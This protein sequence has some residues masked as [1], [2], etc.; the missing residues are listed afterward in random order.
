MIYVYPVIKNFQKG[1]S[2]EEFHFPTF[3]PLSP[4]PLAV[5]IFALKYVM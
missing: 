5:R 1:A 3:V 2:K 4:P